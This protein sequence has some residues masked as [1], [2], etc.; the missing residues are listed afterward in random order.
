ML[1]CKNLAPDLVENSGKFIK[2]VHLG[3]IPLPV[4]LLSSLSTQDFAAFENSVSCNI[5]VFSD[6]EKKIPSTEG[7]NLCVQKSN[8]LKFRVQFTPKNIV[9]MISAIFNGNKATF[10]EMMMRDSDNFHM[11]VE[12]CLGHENSYL[13]MESKRLMLKLN[14]LRNRDEHG[15]LIG[16]TFDAGPNPV[17]YFDKSSSGQN[18]FEELSNW[19]NEQGMHGGFIKG[20]I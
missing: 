5:M 16:Y 14:Y 6:V 1:L 13:S 15:G 19:Q 12:D 10:Y 17:I 11:I 2:Y 18:I 8:L 20:I 4:K 9:K 3:T 7:M